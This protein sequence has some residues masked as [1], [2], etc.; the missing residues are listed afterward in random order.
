M[1]YKVSSH[2][3]NLFSEDFPLAKE[4][5]IRARWEMLFDSDYR[6]DPGYRFNLFHSNPF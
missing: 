3:K 5:Q 4:A 1:V 2:V 6:V